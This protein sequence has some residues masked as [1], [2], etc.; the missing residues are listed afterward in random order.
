MPLLSI[1]YT[2]VERGLLFAVSAVT[3]ALGHMTKAEALEVGKY[4]WPAPRSDLKP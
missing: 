3:T 4:E 1:A 2:F